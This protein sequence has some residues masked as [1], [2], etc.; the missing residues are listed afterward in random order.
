MKRLTN[1][2]TLASL[3]LLLPAIV[4]QSAVA[5]EPT[6]QLD[7][8][9]SGGLIVAG[10]P[11]VSTQFYDESEAPLALPPSPIFSA[12]SEERL[13]T[14]VLPAAGSLKPQ[15]RQA[16]M[17]GP[18]P[19]LRPV[20]N[21]ALAPGGVSAG[22]GGYVHLGAP[23]YPSPRPDIPAWT[24]S[25]MI[26]NPAF[27]PHEMLYPHTY[28]SLHGPFYHRVVGHWVVTPFGVRSHE[29]WQLQGT[30][31]QVKYRSHYPLWPGF[32]PPMTSTMG[33][34]WK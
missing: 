20:S 25:T 21:P 1:L 12:E 24:G 29:K 18:A 7:N 23:L 19:A 11:E 8:E 5:E 22:Q 34:M 30:M 14:P 3:T 15:M 10:G 32:H 4:L 27:A 33:G 6:F 28:R 26:T 17:T 31:V 9:I 13:L 16:I 2:G